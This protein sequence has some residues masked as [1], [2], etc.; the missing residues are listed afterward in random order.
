MLYMGIIRKSIIK[1]ISIVLI[2]AIF[3]SSSAFAGETNLAPL[4]ASQNPMVKRKALAMLKR[5]QVR[6]VESEDAQKL[7]GA[8]DASALLLCSGKLLVTKEVA[9][10]NIRLLR[11]IIHEE[12]EALMQIIAKDEKYRYRNIKELIIKY[13]PPDRNNNLP[14]NFYVNDAVAKAFEWLILVEE[15]VIFRNEIPQEELKFINTIEPIIKESGHYFDSDFWSSGKRWNRIQKALYEGM[16]FYQVASSK[17]DK[18]KKNI[19]KKDENTPKEILSAKTPSKTIMHYTSTTKRIMKR[20]MKDLLMNRNVLLVGERGTGKN[21]IIY[22]LAH[23]IGQSIE[24]LSLNEETTVR[25]LTQRMILVDGKTEWVPSVV[26]EAIKNNRWLIL[27]EIDRAPPGVLSVL[28]NLLQFKEITLPD[29]ERIKAKDGFKIIALMNP[30]TS[31]YAGEELSSE[32]EDRFLIHYIDYLPEDEEVEYLSSIAPSVDKDLIV[33]IV[34]AA[35]D[36]REDYRKGYLPKPFSTRGLVNVVEHLQVY[37]NDPVYGELFR[38]FNLKYLSEE[39]QDTVNKAFKSYDLM[40]NPLKLAEWEDIPSENITEEDFVMDKEKKYIYREEL[41]ISDREYGYIKDEEIEIKEEYIDWIDARELE[42]TEL[43]KILK[44]SIGTPHFENRDIAGDVTSLVVHDDKIVSGH[45]CNKSRVWNLKEGKV[46]LLG[47]DTLYNKEFIMYDNKIVEVNRGHE[48]FYIWDIEKNTR[49][50]LSTHTGEVTSFTVFNGKLVSGSLDQTIRIWDLEEEKVTI[51]K[52]FTEGIKLLTTY[53]DKIVSVDLDGNIYIW[54][55]EKG[56]VERIDVRDNNIEALGIHD[57]KIMSGGF[58]D[59]I[60]VWDMEKRKVK[61]IKTGDR[62]TVLALT[63]YN[64]KIISGNS[65]ATIRIWDLEKNKM[66]ILKGHNR[67]VRSLAIHGNKLISGGFD[68][69]ICIWDL[70]E[71]KLEA[72]SLKALKLMLEGD[73]SEVFLEDKGK[74]LDIGGIEV[75]KKKATAKTPPK[76]IKHYTSTTKRSMKRIIKDLLINRNVLLV[77]ERGT[78]KNSIIY[79]LAHRLGQE[80]EVL[81]LN[82]ETTVRDLTQ[83]MILVDGKTEWVPSVVVEAIKNNRWLILD[84]I[85]RAPPGVLSVLNNLLQFKEITLPDGERIKAGDGFKVIALM[86]PPTS[87]YAGGEL[88]SELEDRFLIHYIDYLPEDEE[89]EYLSSIAPSVDKDLIVKIVRAANDLREDYR[90]GYLPKPFS[91]RG[92]VNV[93]EH[94]EEYPDDSVYGEL[95]RVFNL[96]YLS[97]EYQTTVNKVFTAYDL[98]K[99]PVKLAE[100]EDIPDEDITEE[101]FMPEEKKI[102]KKNIIEEDFEVEEESIAFKEE[103]IEWIDEREFG[104]TELEKTLEGHTDNV[105]S[106]TTKDGKIISAC[107][108]STIRI[109]DLKKRKVRILKTSDHEIHSLAMHDG[110][111]ISGGTEKT[112]RIWDLENNKVKILKGYDKIIWSLTTQDGK[113]ISGER[114]TIC[115]WDLENDKVKRLEGHADDIYSITTQGDKII[116]GNKDRTIRI[117]D[118]ENKKVKILKGHTDAISSL[119]TK[120]GKIISG[121]VDNTIRIWD[122]G[123]KKVKILEG[124]TDNV[125]SLTIQD[126]K[127]ISGSADETIRIWDLENKK[128]KVLKELRESLSDLS[129]LAIQDDKIISGGGRTIRIW[130]LDEA[131]LQTLGLKAMLEGDLSEVFIEDKGKTLDIGGIKVKKKK[132][133]HKTPPKT[134]NHYTSTTKRSMKRIIKDLLMNRNVLLVGERGTGKNSIIYEL[135]HRLGQSIEVLSL[136]EETTVRDLTQRM[137]LVDGKTEWVP[138]V[139]VEAI[140]NNRWLILDEIDRAPPGVLSVLNNLLQFKEITLPDGERI[141]AGDGFKVI[142]LMNPPTSAYAGGELSSE[143]EDRFLIHYIDY[144]PEDEEVEYLSSIAPNVEKD[145]IV[146]IV[147]AANDLREDYR[148]GYL[149]KPF[150]TRGLVNVVE[151]L[152]V[153]PNDPVYGELFRVFNLKYLSDEYQDTVNKVFKSYG[154]MKNLVRIAEWEDIPSENITEEDFTP[155][156]ENIDSQEID[157][158]DIKEEDVEEKDIEYEELDMDWVG[159]SGLEIT[160]LEKILIAHNNRVW[161]LGTDNK[162]IISS[163]EDGKLCIWDIKNQKVK[164]IKRNRYQTAF[165]KVQNGVIISGEP[166]DETVCVWDIEQGRVK[167]FKTPDSSSISG[168]VIYDDKL[169]VGGGSEITMWDFDQ[170]KRKVFKGHARN[171]QSMVVLDGKIVFGSNLT[172]RI[173]DPEEGKVK[174]LKGHYGS[175]SA[176]ATYEGKIVSTDNSYKMRIWDLEEGKVKIFRSYT[177]AILSLAIYDNKIISGGMDKMIRVWDLKNKKVKVL[178]GHS[179]RVW[180]LI[181]DN[182]KLI[183]GSFDKTIRIWDLDEAKLQTLGLKAMLEGD[184]SEVFIE[185]KGKTLDIGGIKVKKKDSRFRGNDINKIPPKTINHYTSTTKRSMKRIIKDLLMNRNVLLVGERGTGKNSIIYELAHR[186]G[187]EIEV[188]SLNEET[189]VRDLTQRMILVD[190]KTEWVPSVVVEAIKNN[191]WLILDEIDRAPPGVLSVL[192]NLLQFKEITLPDGERIK[193]GDGF[194]VIALMNPPTSAYAGGELSSELED[195]FLIHY[196]DYLPEDEEVEYLSSIAPSVEKDLIVR[197]VRAAN[198]LRE[199]YRKG[200]LPKPFS[201]RGLVN[202]VEHLQVYPKDPVYGELFRVFNLKYLS[203][204]YQETVNKVF[205]AYGLMPKESSKLAE[206]QDIPDEDIKEEKIILI[207]EDE[208]SQES[209][210]IIMK[211]KNIEVIEEDMYWEYRGLDVTELEKTLRG[212]TD[213]VTSLVMH[214]GKLISGGKDGIVRIWDTE[215]KKVTIVKKWYLRDILTYNS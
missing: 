15:N 184:L 119:A 173:W 157:I 52:N 41:D 70:D 207:D 148:K 144:L 3:V 76:T 100:W 17:R 211:E 86:N 171:I 56:E 90:K 176:L 31:A 26:V 93:V 61:A 9:E 7:L 129:L 11:T 134:I 141:K 200:Y 106:L 97:E 203:E 1:A 155:E 45:A 120:D 43:E 27:D 42:I 177:E 186:L 28:N 103:D 67:A 53:D 209:F 181:V 92:L 210:E 153:Y 122:L 96:K 73:L 81:S 152:Q 66:K 71:D 160:E 68:K 63:T 139:V 20:I 32:L 147:R 178:E 83:R 151:H 193:A 158:I 116:T 179:D 114:S 107:C 190:G 131:K 136:N 174:I 104:I 166:W 215:K 192:N 183:S 167:I 118:L 121:S 187:Q 95:F 48:D 113:I 205:T 50:R 94:L 162:K 39:Y 198:D 60:H 10:D 65:D 62:C 74:N 49:K 98:M 99:N 191:R 77:G 91:T 64:G 175:I 110:K 69:T 51:F 58:D 150:S 33:R 35:N 89:V 146:R 143:L 12:I 165:L 34:R 5:M 102:K 80:I 149:P 124:H 214:D 182:D 197:I 168:A 195:R 156:E 170:K 212:H 188:L 140:K 172:V 169:V 101:D 142:A 194:K 2:G 189:T 123:N 79:E 4:P 135:A 111:I 204:E 185:D 29:G 154:L 137:I 36:L 138:S 13:F 88:S 22:E 105:S 59:T 180:S 115:I 38:V 75:E 199:D 57:G 44:I 54:D 24:I 161:H 206:W 164:I 25:D 127:I 201:T 72:L 109:W 40:R 208:Y 87:A 84:E 16:K 159:N 19:K 112:I 108:D 55:V 14:I 21:S 46:Y 145:L 78:G 18:P 163:G 128:M 202:V 8:N 117:W 82:E 30:P 47:R 125:Y 130:D 85:D 23:R 37:P 196:I 213:G 132:P 126:G 6:Y 133:T